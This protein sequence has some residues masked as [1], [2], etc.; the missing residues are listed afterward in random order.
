MFR[1]T[2]PLVW[3]SLCVGFVPVFSFTATDQQRQPG[4]VDRPLP[5]VDSDALSLDKKPAEV[6]KG[7]QE[8]TQEKAKDNEKVISSLKS[9]SF[10]GHAVLA[11]DALQAVAKPYIGKS[12]G[13]A[14]LAKLKYDLTRAF[15]DRGYILVK[16]ATPPQ[17][18]SD[19][20]LE[21]EIYEAKVGDVKLHN[22][23][24]LKSHIA[25]AISGQVKTGEV[26]DETRVESM[27]SD[28]N[29]L[30]GVQ[31]S[32]TLQQGK[33]FLA[34]DLHLNLDK[35]DENQHRLDLDNYGAKLTGTN[36]ATLH[37]EHSNHFGLGETLA[38]QGRRSS[39]D[40][41]ST[42][43]SGD[44]PI[45]YRN[46]KLEL[47]YLHS[48]N[49]IGDRLAALDAE[50]ESNIGTV[51]LSS[52]LL[53]THEQQVTVR[54]GY[55]ARNHKSFL[56]D[57]RDTKD[58]IRQLFAETTYLRRSR[59][60]ISYG[61]VKVKQGV[62]IMGASG[63][64]DAGNSRAKGDPQAFIAQPTLYG[65]YRPT[66]KGKI[67]AL[68]NGQ[69]AT[70]TLLSSDLFILGGYGSVRGFE[71]A[72][73]TGEGG[74]NFSLEYDHEIVV[75][76]QW[77]VTLG[78]WVDGGTVYNRIDGAVQDKNLYSVGM[79]L[80]ATSQIVPDGEETTFRVDWALPVGHYTS[81]DVANDFVYL[82]ISQPF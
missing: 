41:W 6:L 40:M 74:Y 55:E 12:M 57:V 28:L 66:D 62:D 16:V 45:G 39:D 42:E 38:F 13:N 48:E 69:I 18:L 51:G 59:G 50:G 4:V 22:D 70:D 76:E 35:V 30:K 11:E 8:L 73:E 68:L 25:N 67:T 10:K 14:D 21:V 7:K 23:G 53:N 58:D 32:A 46:L 65:R 81:S 1:K 71:P 33:Q 17:N 36:A 43:F 2:F 54:G 26:F 61:A 60:N 77:Q 82:R 27:V 24:V 47:S 56:F 29:D 3:L 79:G 52:K 37:L 9:V 34:S 44:S 80:E 64:S 72:Q 31:A 75:H 20:T 78:P 15:Y 63:K 5:K 19:G 49:A